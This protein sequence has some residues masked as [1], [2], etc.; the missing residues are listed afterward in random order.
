VLN[1]PESIVASLSADE[2]L[3][4]NPFWKP[5][6]IDNQIFYNTENTL[7][8][9][10]CVGAED[11]TCSDRFNVLDCNINDHLSY[12][13]VIMGQCAILDKNTSKN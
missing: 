8:Y 3:K 9:V 7:S 4:W 11:P 5:W 10:S 1:D 2:D 13:G 6:H 12:L